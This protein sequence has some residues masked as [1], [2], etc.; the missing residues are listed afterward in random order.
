MQ[1]TPHKN[2]PASGEDSPE[3]R[4]IALRALTARREATLLPGAANAL[5]ARIIEDLGFQAVYLTGA[6][7]TNTSLGLPDLGLI[8]ATEIADATA[9]VSEV[10]RLPL[11][12]DID[13]GFGNA[14]NAYSTVRKV[15]RAGAA[16]LQIEDQVFP[17][18]CGH[19]AG[20]AIVP[21]AEMLGKLKACLDARRD[22]NTMIIARTDARA[23]EG[24]DAAMDRAH[25]MAE[26]GADMLFV[27]APVS[28]EE[29]S[30][31][32]Q[33]ETPQL[34]NF[35]FGGET[36]ML[37]LEELRRKGFSFVLY[38][39]AALQASI[40]AQQ[41]VLSSLIQ[42]GSLAEVR[43]DLAGFEERQRVIGKPDLD[44]LL[45]RYEGS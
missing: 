15:E 17:K 28:V 39:N 30:T 8:T 13:T 45:A 32:G 29:I 44:A 16:A 43:D 41:R 37:E 20:K 11:I 26:T 14:L 23:V 25:Q 19:F 4:R 38:A 9:R 35:V 1:V 6:G 27:E 2:G 10:C 42:S 34:I 36:P 24:F 40:K 12:V 5:S 31:I 21:I 3:A 7:V 22:A 33:L 18:K